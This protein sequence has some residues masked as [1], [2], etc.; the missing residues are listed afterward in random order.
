MTTKRPAMEYS[1]REPTYQKSETWF[2]VA[3]NYRGQPDSVI[4]YMAK[5]ENAM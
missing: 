2:R 4:N 1:L 3:T 5:T